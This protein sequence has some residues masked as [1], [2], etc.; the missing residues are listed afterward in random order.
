MSLTK[1]VDGVK[2]A[3]TAD[4]EAGIRAF[5][6]ANDPANKPPEP[7]RPTLDDLIEAVSAI[8][9]ARAV[10]DTKVAAANALAIEQPVSR[11][12]EKL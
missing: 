4:E 11:Q 7:F 5:W 1:I 3:M 2:T 6:A 9:E 12:M 10:L 8:P